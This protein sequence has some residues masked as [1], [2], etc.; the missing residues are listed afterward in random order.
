MISASHLHRVFRYL[1]TRGRSGAPAS[2][3]AASTVWTQ[4][5]GDPAE[6]D[7]YYSK[8]DQPWRKLL[9]EP[10]VDRATGHVMVHVVQRCWHWNG[11][12]PELCLFR[13]SRSPRPSEPKPESESG[14]EFDPDL[15]PDLD[16]DS[17]WDSKTDSESSG[18]SGSSESTRHG[19]RPP[20]WA[21][22]LTAP[23][24]HM[25]ERG[26]LDSLGLR[27]GAE[28]PPEPP[29]PLHSIDDGDDAIAELQPLSSEDDN[30][31]SSSSSPPPWRF[32]ITRTRRARA[33]CPDCPTEVLLTEIR[34]GT[35]SGDL[36]EGAEVILD[37]WQDFSCRLPTDP[38]ARH[39]RVRSRCVLR[40]WPVRHN[41]PTELPSDPS[42]LGCG[43]D[44]GD[45][46]DSD[47]SD[48]DDDGGRA[49][50]YDDEDSDTSSVMSGPHFWSS[51]RKAVF[52]TRGG[53]GAAADLATEAPQAL[54]SWR[55]AIAT[56]A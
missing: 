42:Q 23:C 31:N 38:P 53:I 7:P 29:R 28:P 9:V 19:R 6:D 32:P 12:N 24:A 41:R 10:H 46:S 34:Y 52:P 33:A 56:A 25:E 26:E 16:R 54:L 13:R 4:G 44:D 40:C 50:D 1:R 3:L 43:G 2:S 30:N 14:S 45:G 15:D 20:W 39:G 37:S 11:A 35:D 5:D 8:G 51:R 21:D 17:N 47:D 55:N 49:H 36:A 48:E 18:S 22:H 27:L